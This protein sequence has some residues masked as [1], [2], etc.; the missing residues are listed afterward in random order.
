MRL[1][2]NQLFSVN[3]LRL[4]MGELDL[5]ERLFLLDKTIN[6]VFFVVFLKKIFMIMYR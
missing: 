6:S 4:K 3:E 1:Q 5:V 2:F